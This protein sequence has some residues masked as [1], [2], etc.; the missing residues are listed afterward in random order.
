MQIFSYENENKL[1]SIENKLNKLLTS[2]KITDADVA[3]FEDLENKIN[4]I[5][6]NELKLKEKKD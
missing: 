3:L 2:N 5:E 6:T 4:E 1:N